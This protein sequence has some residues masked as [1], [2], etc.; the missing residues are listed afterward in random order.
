VFSD[1]IATAPNNSVVTD[2]SPKMAI[3]SLTAVEVEMTGKTI[4]RQLEDAN[5]KMH[6]CVKYET[7]T[8]P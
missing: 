4:I 6:F 5:N 2:G 3:S 8:D 7:T 1:D